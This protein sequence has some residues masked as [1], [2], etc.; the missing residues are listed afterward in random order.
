MSV[1]TKGN[2]LP[3][4][5]YVLTAYLKYFSVARKAQRH[6][7]SL[8]GSNMNNFIEVMSYSIEIDFLAQT[9]KCFHVP[10]VTL[11]MYRGLFGVLNIYCWYLGDYAASEEKKPF[12]GGKW[13]AKG[14]LPCF[15]EVH[16]DFD[17]VTSTAA[18][19]SKNLTSSTRAGEV[20]LQSLIVCH[21]LLTSFITRPSTRL[22]NDS[23]FLI[24]LM[25]TGEDFWC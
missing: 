18:E 3:L 5:F 2:N 12:G 6:F 14:K 24:S 22:S 23:V 25:V 21:T 1:K 15:S 10:W 19:M 8:E 7:L 11:P 13:E 16:P 9:C 17:S 4:T 20:S